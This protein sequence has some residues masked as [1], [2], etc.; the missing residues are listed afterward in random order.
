MSGQCKTCAHWLPFEETRYATIRLGLCGRI[1]NTDA[2][3]IDENDLAVAT[4]MSGM[5]A[6][7]TAPG[8]GC[9]MH[10]EKPVQS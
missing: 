9:V 1:K 3:D 4:D 8:F 10:S 2:S 5:A 7:R 6:L